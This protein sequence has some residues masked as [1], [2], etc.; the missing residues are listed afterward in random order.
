M[1]AAYQGGLLLAAVNKDVRPLRRAL[2]GVTAAVLS[3]RTTEASAGERD[4]CRSGH[5]GAAA[6]VSARNWRIIEWKSGSAVK[7]RL[8]AR[9][10][11]ILAGQLSTIAA[12]AGS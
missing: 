6:P 2:R 7:P 9:R 1:L 10:L 8:S 5:C 3:V 4:S 12:M 11:L